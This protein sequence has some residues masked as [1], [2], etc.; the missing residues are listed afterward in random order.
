MATTVDQYSES[1]IDKLK[2]LLR[3]KKESGVNRW[4]EI[5]VDNLRV[6]QK[7]DNLDEFDKYKRYVDEGTGQVKIVVYYSATSPKNE[8]YQY[9][10]D[11][12]EVS[13]SKNRPV[14]GA[15]LQEMVNEKLEAR[16]QEFIW[17]T[18]Q[19]EFQR[20]IESLQESMLAQQKEY[21]KQL[22]E[23]DEEI[24]DAEEYTDELQ[25][26]VKELEAALSKKA[27][28]FGQLLSAGAEHFLRSN[29]HRLK[30]IPLLG[31]IA[32]MFNAGDGN[33][34]QPDQAGGADMSF[35][36]AEDDS[37]KRTDAEIRTLEWFSTIESAFSPTQMQQYIQLTELLV[38]APAHIEPLLLHV[39]AA[40]RQ[41]AGSGNTSNTD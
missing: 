16:E 29:A 9:T 31:G 4:F 37:P 13:Y 36:P 24:G 33:S 27:I 3:D 17:R 12:E 41:S 40:V 14:N 18:K 28:P 2:T 11:E 30:K 23:K 6:V 26:R 5:F 25:K 1:R 22:K 32:T 20:K 19:M 34:S 10:Q 15:D 39:A 8:T 21:D 7:T 38:H 35:T